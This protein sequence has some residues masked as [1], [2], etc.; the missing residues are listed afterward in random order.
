MQR[1]TTLTFL[2]CFITVIFISEPVARCG[3]RPL[4]KAELLALVAGDILP[5][6]IAFDIQSRGLA[7]VPDASYKSLLKS[8]GAD[9]KVFAAISAA[10]TTPE[11]AGASDAQLLQHLSHAGEL[12]KSGKLDDAGDELTDAL[13]RSSAKSE[14]GFVMGMVLIKQT[15]YPEAGAI[16]SQILSEDPGF[17]ELHTRLSTTYYQTGDPDEALRQTKAALAENPNNP[18]AHMNAAV[19][20][21]ALQHFD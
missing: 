9:A 12:I 11:T 7:F 2:L 1:K 10:K 16:Y 5:E 8:A 21:Q 15:R 20:L 6:N 18:A 4:S 14:I 17:P 13:T 3:P 19:S